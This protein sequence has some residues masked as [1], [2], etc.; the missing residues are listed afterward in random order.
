MPAERTH[1]SLAMP[2]PLA[3]K[4]IKWVVITPANVEASF[5]QLE[6]KGQPVVLFA[7]TDD[8]YQQLAITMSD[9]RN[10]IATQHNI[11]IKYKEYYEP[12]NTE[13]VK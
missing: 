2:D 13:A 8:G 11:I 7:I 10:F 1:L 4:P 12:V 3:I 5:K 9:L 6:T